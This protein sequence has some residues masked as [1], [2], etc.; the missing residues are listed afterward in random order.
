MNCAHTFTDAVIQNLIGRCPGDAYNNQV[1]RLGNIEDTRIVLYPGGFDSL[2][3][4]CINLN[5]IELGLSPT[6]TKH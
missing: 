2:G 3:S 6:T 5:G 4:L 1:Y